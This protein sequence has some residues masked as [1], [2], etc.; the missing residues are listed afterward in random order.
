MNDNCIYKGMCDIECTS[1][2]M[3]YLEMNYLLETSNIP[4]SKRKINTL[5]PD[6][7]D[8]KAFEKL[9]DIR[10]NIVDFVQQGTSLYIFSDRVGNGKT[11]WAIKL[12]LQY[13]NE[14]WAGN[15]FTP[16]GI[17]VNVPTFLTMNKNIISLPD[18]N[19]EIMR[20]Q[21]PYVDLVIFDDI[22]STKLSD[23]DYNMLLTYIDQRVVSEKA[24]IYTGNIVPEHLKDFVGSRLKSRICGKKNVNGMQVMLKGSDKR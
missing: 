22:A 13:F 12:M 17:F 4:K 15:G 3:K 23:Y 11:T 18:K 14:V 21:L 19:F 8:V 1:R 24:T 9:A 6:S 7:I 10:D 5:I 2:C 20:D 16:R